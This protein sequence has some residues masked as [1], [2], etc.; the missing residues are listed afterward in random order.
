VTGT[1]RRLW[2]TAGWLVLASVVITLAGAVFQP[3][4]TIGDKSSHVVSGLVTAS[5][6]KTFTG[7]YIEF[8]ATLVF[9][10]GALLLAQLLRGEGDLP[11]WLS[12]CIVA[13][14]IVNAAVEIAAG[15]A[16]V[17]AVYNAHHGAP[18]PL[19]TTVNDIRNVA[20]SLSGGVLGLFALAVGA[21]GQLTRLLPRW[22]AYTGYAVGVLMI[23]AVPAAKAGAPQVLLWF[24][25]MVALGVV[26]LRL[27]R[28]SP[29]P[30]GHAV[31][32][33]A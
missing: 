3:N 18:L 12:S 1:S 32:A 5:M 11:A 15:A 4:V 9:L 6:S 21:A 2:L 30:A 7:G 33:T 25:W 29:V 20:F 31:V 22:F 28:R 26:A 24:A 17:A 10:V 8:I 13:A 23:A 16:G 14:A 27:P 19:V